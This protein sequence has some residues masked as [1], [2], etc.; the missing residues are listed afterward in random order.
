MTW[1]YFTFQNDTLIKQITAPGK[2][3]LQVHDNA[4]EINLIGSVYQR[5]GG[6]NR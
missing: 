5:H 6:L 1:P 2:R 4:E 3:D